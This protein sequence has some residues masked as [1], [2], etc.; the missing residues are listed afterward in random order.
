MV[1]GHVQAGEVV[2]VVLN[3]G[4]LINFKAHAG[5][6]VDD[7]VLDQR[8]G[9]KGAGFAAG[10]GQRDIHGLRLVAGGQLGSLDGFRERFVLPFHPDLELVDGLAGGGAVLPGHIPQRL[11][12]AGDAAVFAQV[13]LPEGG[14][15]LFAVHGGAVGFQFRTQCCDFFFHTTPLWITHGAGPA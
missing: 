5:K 7:L 6:D 3:L 8:D 10:A 9:M 11:G 15:L 12:Q 2:V 13:F 14:K 1:L 4:A